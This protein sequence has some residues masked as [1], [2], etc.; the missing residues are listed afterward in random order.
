[1]IKTGISFP[2]QDTKILPIVEVLDNAQ[3][4]S[5][6]EQENGIKTKIE[7]NNSKNGIVECPVCGHQNKIVN[8]ESL[9]E[10]K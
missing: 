10:P 5:K 2:S 6:C 1:M 7:L 8:M 3:F 4:C 9:D